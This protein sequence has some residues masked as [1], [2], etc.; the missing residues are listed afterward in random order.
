MPYAIAVGDTYTIAD[1]CPRTWAACVARSN[2]LNFK[3][4]P[5]IPTGDS[6]SV[7]TPGAQVPRAGIISQIASGVSA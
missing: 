1:T 2:Q 3:G 5:L 7:S 6:P 4:E